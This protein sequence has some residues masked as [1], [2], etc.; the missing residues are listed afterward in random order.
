MSELNPTAPCAGRRSGDPGPDRAVRDGLPHAV[1]GT[2]DGRSGERAESTWERWGEEAR[3]PGK[4]QNAALMARR[5]VERG[6]R[7]VRFYQPGMGRPLRPA[8]R[9][10]R[11]RPAT[12]TRAALGADSGPERSAALFDGDPGHLGRRV[13]SHDLLPGAAHRRNLRPGSPSALL[14]HLDG[15]RRGQ[16]AASSTARRDDFSYNIVKD[17]VPRPRLPGDG[18]PPV[19]HRPRAV[20]PPAPGA[21]RPAEPASRRRGWSREVLA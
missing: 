12:S 10:C 9:A 4:F 1:V 3:Q 2:R 15:R 11:R 6:V 7:F 8:D 13:R 18:A 17:P 14:Q 19:R 5:L 21:R 20:H 16:G